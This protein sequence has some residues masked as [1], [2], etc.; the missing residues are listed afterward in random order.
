MPACRD[1]VFYEAGAGDGRCRINPPSFLPGSDR[2]EG[3]WPLVRPDDWCGLY[4][5][6]E[7]QLDDSNFTDYQAEGQVYDPDPPWRQS[8]F[9]EERDDPWT[10]TGYT[11]P[12]AANQKED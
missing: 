8:P 4:S 1:C 9:D 11:R 7:T 2:A 10:D 6:Q 5:P 12:T 3:H